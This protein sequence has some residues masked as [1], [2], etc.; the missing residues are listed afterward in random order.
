MG[1]FLSNPNLSLL[2]SFLLGSFCSRQV[3][4]Y[5]KIFWMQWREAYK[6]KWCIKSLSNFNIWYPFIVVRYLAYDWVGSMDCFSYEYSY[7]EKYASFI[8]SFILKYHIRVCSYNLRNCCQIFGNWCTMCIRWSLINKRSLLC[9]LD[10]YTSYEHTFLHES[11]SYFL[12]KR[13]RMGPWITSIRRRRGRWLNNNNN[14][15][16]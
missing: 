6:S 14:E 1:A 8:Q 13:C 2:L 9:S 12:Y 4:W 3:L 16:A 11:L 5:F 10:Y 15:Y 7:G